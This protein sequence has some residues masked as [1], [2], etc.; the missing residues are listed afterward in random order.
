MVFA[1]WLA[2]F[3]F[4]SP[5]FAARPVGRTLAAAAGAITPNFQAPSLEAPCYRIHFVLEV[6]DD[7]TQITGVVLNGT[8]VSS[9]LV[10]NQG[11]AVEPSSPLEKG[12]YDVL[13]DYA[14]SSGKKYAATLFYQ[15]QGRNRPAKY[16]VKGTSPEAG[17]I[18]GGQEGFYR[19]YT[20]E[21]EAG[22]ERRQETVALT[23]TAPND[24]LAGAGLVIF[25]RGQPVP[26]EIIGQ[27]ESVPNEKVAATDPVTMTYKIVL[28]LDAAARER[29]WLLVVKGANPAETPQDIRL[30]GEGLGK[31]IRTPRLS[32]EFSPESGQVDSIEA[33]E[34]AVTLRNRAG[35]IHWNPDVFVDGLYWDHSFN[36]NPP[37]AF[38]EKAG[39]LVYINSRRGPMPH[40]RDVFLDIRYTIDAAAPY[41]ISETRLDFKKDIGVIAARN[42]EMVLDRELFDSLLYR[43]KTGGLVKL[44]L[45]EME[46][47]PNGLAHV[48]PPDL[49]WVGLV[50]TVKGYGFFSLRVEATNGN[51]ELPGAFLHK[52]ATCFYAPSEGSYVYWVRP[53]VYTWADYFTNRFHS[54]VPKGSF[55][56]EKNAYGVW[57]MTQDLPRRL[58]ELVLK[59][60][61]PLR[62]Y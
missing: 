46:G 23:L 16:E 59:L 29:R 30:S 4:A 21:E 35:V 17:G 40:I 43:D 9:F 18:P 1:V 27:G 20:V 33:S 51:L 41:F 13:L 28:R 11:K 39:G 60:R 6:K 32:I 15:T 47:A 5:S 58:D 2:S 22:L 7:K 31:T 50:N 55:F 62:I 42:D 26:Y 10:L 44:P 48:A 37:A 19:I 52:A 34:P 25:D 8:R 45:K 3:G 38:E 49:D 24:Q 53:L 14:W 12:A 36:W 54:F 61:H 56:Y 57:R